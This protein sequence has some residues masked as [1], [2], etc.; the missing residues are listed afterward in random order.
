M[1]ERQIWKQIKILRSD[2]GGEY[3][4]DELIRYCKDHGILQQFTV[5]HTPQQNGVT[6]RKSRTLV[7]CARSMLKGKN[8]RMFFGL[9]Q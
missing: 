1:I 6:E 2:Q 5:P 7:E 9:K 4:K 3:R 8:F